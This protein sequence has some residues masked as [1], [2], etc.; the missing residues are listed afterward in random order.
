MNE[1]I[2]VEE[3]VGKQTVNARDLHE[4][5]GVK[6]DFRRWMRDQKQYF[7]FV[8]GEDFIP[9]VG[10]S[11]GGRPT[12]EYAFSAGA[13]KYIA[14]TSK[15]EVGK[16]I[17]KYLVDC[18]EAWNTPEALRH[19]LAQV[20]PPELTMQEYEEAF[21][22]MLTADKDMRRQMSGVHGRK[23]PS[24]TFEE[25]VELY[26]KAVSE[27]LDFTFSLHSAYRYSERFMGALQEYYGLDNAAVLDIVNKVWKKIGTKA[28]YELKGY[29]GRMEP[30]ALS[31]EKKKAIEY[32]PPR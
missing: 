27:V 16:K 29:N 28:Y 17:R 23:K 32:I 14:A 12:K 11:T 20:A 8:E 18:E 5:L 6:T 1:L 15:S 31:E 10:E 26:S 13:A 4:A 25:T 24:K 22:R 3:R 21:T 7:N 30:L 9:Y 2:K 19:R